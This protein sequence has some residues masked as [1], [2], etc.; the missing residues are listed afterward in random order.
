MHNLFVAKKVLS[1]MVELGLMI[2]CKGLQLS[3]G[4]AVPNDPFLFGLEK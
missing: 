4:G 1:L 3:C 2:L